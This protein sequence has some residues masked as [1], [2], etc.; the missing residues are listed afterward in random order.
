[1]KPV[2]GIVG[3][4]IF[5]DGN[6]RNAVTDSIRRAIIRAGG[7]PFLILPPQNIDYYHLQGN[8][9]SPMTEEEKA[10]L[11]EQ[12]SFCKGIV[13]PGGNRM[14]EYDYYILEYAICHDIPILGICMGMQIMWKYPRQIKNI[15][16]ETY[17]NHYSEKPFVHSIILSKSSFLSKICG[18]GRFQVNSRHYYHIDESEKSNYYQIVG[19]SEDGIPEAIECSQNRFNIGVQWHPELLLEESEISKRLLI[20]F[21]SYCKDS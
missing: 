7:I 15:K 9:V 10:M 11:D 12:L 5:V 21:L 3:R 1:M 19:Y 13:L 6:V 2:I 4:I 18:E 20:V 17:I 16:N 8:D 14:Y